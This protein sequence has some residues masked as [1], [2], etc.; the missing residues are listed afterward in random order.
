MKLAGLAALAALL[1]SG[2]ART[3]TLVHFSDYHSHAVPF[4]A[5]G[6][7]EAAGIAR[8]VA[9]IE[10]LSRRDDVLVF[11]GGDTMNRGAPAF[12]DK[13]RCVEW[14]WWNGVVDA[15]AFG[16]HDADFGAKAFRACAESASYPILS[17][18]VLDPAG[19]PVFAPGGKRYQVFE[20][21]GARI[22]VFALAGDDFTQ[23]LKPET[24]PVEGVRFADRAETAREII[25]ELREV[26]KVDAVVLIGHAHNH[27]DEALAKAVPGIDLILGTHSHRVVELV[28]IDGTATWMIASGQYLEHL[29]RVEMKFER[30]RL[31]SVA[32]EVV[33]MAR[34]LSE[35]GETK[36][37]VAELQRQLESDPAFAPLFVVAGRLDRELGIVA[38]NEENAPL[39]RFVMDAVRSA[40]NADVAISTSSSFRAALPPGPVRETDLRD[41]LPYDNAILRF[42]IDGATLAA[43]LDRAI[44]LRGTDSF[45]QLSGV[46]LGGSGATSL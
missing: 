17:A 18:N 8:A 23:L 20:P 10:P 21:R 4:Y 32:G 24:S 1:A 45:L 27:E 28:R 29:S 26:E 9:Y 44:S 30:G 46:T 39:G 5:S 16:N 13:F 14:P 12:S 36:R 15:M 2:C 41:A 37:K 31:A 3:V 40:A 34:A 38:L 6:E 42:E 35:D 25:R 19:A 22:G 33:R 7:S 43:I 11:N